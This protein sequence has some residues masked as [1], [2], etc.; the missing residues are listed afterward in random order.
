MT[1]QKKREHKEIVGSYIFKKT[2]K[3]NE[4]ILCYIYIVMI[5]HQLTKLFKHFMITY[6][7]F[8]IN[9]LSRVN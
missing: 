3:N 7:I 1:R 4:E 2:T 9:I 6:P 5:T 8:L